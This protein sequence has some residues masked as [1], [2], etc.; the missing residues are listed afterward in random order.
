MTM[1]SAINKTTAIERRKQVGGT[2][3]TDMDVQ[4]WDVI[5][6]WNTDQRIGY[7]RGN[8]IKYI[9]RMGSK[10]EQIAEIQKAQHYLSKLITTLEETEP[11]KL[12]SSKANAFAIVHAEK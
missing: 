10:D 3:Y 8:A 5:D 2:H 4:P 11:A 1:P 12:L 9:M 6:T 7:Y